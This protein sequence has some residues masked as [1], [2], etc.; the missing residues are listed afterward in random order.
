MSDFQTINT[1]YAKV[2]SRDC[3]AHSCV[4]VRALPLG[5]LVEVIVVIVSL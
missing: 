1:E 3:P 5:G 2:F 4:A